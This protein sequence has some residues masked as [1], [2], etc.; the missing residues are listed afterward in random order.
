MTAPRHC[1]FSDLGE[2]DFPTAHALQ[3][4]ILEAR[5]TGASDADGFLLLEHTPVVTLGRGASLSHLKISLDALRGNGVR[6]SRIERG[7]DI[8]YHGPGQLVLYPIVRLKSYGIGVREF[9]VRLEEVMIRTARDFDVPATRDPRN[10]GVWAHG[11]KM[12][13]GV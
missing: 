8:T 1:W 12:A 6:I 7:G 13:D 10:H 9:V 2:I 5:I 3:L 4:K 11:K